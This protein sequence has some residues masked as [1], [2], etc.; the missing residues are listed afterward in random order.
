M[1]GALIIDKPEGLTSHDVVARVRRAAQTRRVGHAGTLDPFATGVLV[2]CLAR[3]T[4]LLQF[5]VGFDKEY[6]A[7]VRLGFATDTQDYTGK[8][9]TPLQSSELLSGEEVATILKAFVGAQWQTPP[10]FS[11]KKVAGERLYVAAR[12]GREVERQPVAITIS[13]LELLRLGEMSAEGTRDFL[14]RVRCSSGTYVRTLAHDIGNRLGTGAHL[15]AL[16]RTAVGHFRI[17]DAL[18]LAEVERRGGDGSLG[19]AMIS[20]AAMLSHLPMLQIGD[21]DLR[22]VLNGRELALGMGADSVGAMVPPVTRICDR[23]GDLVAVG[24][25]DSGRRLIKPRVVLITTD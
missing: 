8:Q 24:Q 19:E 5:L 10:M 4:R 9:I 6:L 16:R 11:A 25:V 14:I 23:A 13:E 17:E 15:S 1:I 22:L 3:A 2:V 7:T 12:A 20:P 18:T 21:A